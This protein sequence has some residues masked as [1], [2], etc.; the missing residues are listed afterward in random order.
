MRVPLAGLTQDAS[1]ILSGGNFTKE[2]FRHFF[3]VRDYPNGPFN[4]LRF[5]V[6]TARGMVLGGMA[7]TPRVPAKPW[8]GMRSY[9]WPF[10]ANTQWDEA[11]LHIGTAHARCC[12]GS[13][14]CSDK[15]RSA[16]CCDDQGRLAFLRFTTSTRRYLPRQRPTT[17][18]WQRPWPSSMTTSAGAEKTRRIT[19]SAAARR[20]DG[21]STAIYG[22]TILSF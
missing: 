2:T 11:L 20:V 6:Y 21:L 3:G 19:Q 4:V 14:L 10:G 12:M 18:R 13:D 22:G 16:S 5:E 9:G 7:S 8:I 1:R 15:S 17:R